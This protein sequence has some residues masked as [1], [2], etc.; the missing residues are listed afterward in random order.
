M[1]RPSH[2]PVILHHPLASH[3]LSVLRN[4][5]TPPESFRRAVQRLSTLLCVEATRDF[6]VRRGRVHTPLAPA[7]SARLATRMGLVPILR[8]GLGMVDPILDLLPEAE[9][10]HLGLYRDERTRD[11]VEYYKKFPP[12][13]P[14]RIALVLDPMLATGGSSCS[15]LDAVRAWGVRDVRLLSIL[16]APE[17]LARVRASHP[18]VR[19]YV[20]G[21]DRKLNARAFIVPGL[22]DAGDRQFNTMS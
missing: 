15:A 2:S 16:A 3:H 21:V 13:S 1:S 12:K 9:V 17:G 20:A 19:V 7:P 8:A 6:P 22:G 11:P 18:D 10:W 5:R 4:R 14:V